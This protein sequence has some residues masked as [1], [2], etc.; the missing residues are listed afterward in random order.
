M[1]GCR[2]GRAPRETLA[3]K[4]RRHLRSYKFCI[5]L[6]TSSRTRPPNSVRLRP[7]FSQCR[8]ISRSVGRIWAIFGKSLAMIG[9][10]RPGVVRFHPLW[11]WLVPRLAR[12][13]RSPPDLDQ[14]GCAVGNVE[15]NS[16]KFGATLAKRLVQS[17]SML[18]E[19]GPH[20]ANPGPTLGDADRTWSDFGQL[21]PGQVQFLAGSAK[22]WAHIR[23]NCGQGLAIS[24]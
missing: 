14:L 18:A 5:D 22:P 8:P 21:L 13:D 19:F 3:P 16:A 4:L 9:R 17:F 12:F 24:T 20:L 11:A 10:C 2:P 15:A 23:S 1:E 7:S 6:V